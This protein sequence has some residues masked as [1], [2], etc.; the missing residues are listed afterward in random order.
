MLTDAEKEELEF[1]LVGENKKEDT[2]SSSD[3]GFK[4]IEIEEDSDDEEE[5]VPAGG[6]NKELVDKLDLLESKKTE[7][8]TMVKDG[9]HEKAINVFQTAIN[10]FCLE[11][12]VYVDKELKERAYKLRC[13]L[14][15][16]IA[17]ANMQ[18]DMPKRVIRACDEVLEIATLSKKVNLPEDKALLEK[19]YLRRALQYEKLDHLEKAL[20]DYKMVKQCNPGNLKASQGIRTCSMSL[21]IDK[22]GKYVPEKKTR[23]TSRKASR[24]VRRSRKY[25][26][27]HT[28]SST[29]TQRSPKK[30]DYPRN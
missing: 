10:S 6:N 8:A 9:L 11:E 2:P 18:L 21:G 20:E 5:E 19:T 12:F 1:E 14:W 29:L 28:S 4:R 23:K 7:G 15:S 22:T 16:N 30:R 3:Q 26:Q 13:G 27:V 17:F 25:S 24:K